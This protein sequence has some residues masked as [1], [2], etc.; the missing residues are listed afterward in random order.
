MDIW[1]AAQNLI[2]SSVRECLEDGFDPNT[3]DERGSTLL[4]KLCRNTHFAHLPEWFEMIKLLLENGANV[5]ITC[6][7]NITPLMYFT[8]IEDVN[9]TDNC[10]NILHLLLKYGANPNLDDDLLNC[11]Y[12]KYSII[13]DTYKNVILINIVLEYV[14]LQ[15][16]KQTVA[17]SK[18]LLDNI[19]SPLKELDYDTLGKLLNFPRKYYPKV[20]R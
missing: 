10:I 18:C 7:Y 16:R 13:D 3:E 6:R 2:V 15:Q 1:L 17:M 9:V 14:E 19:N 20:V 11:A 5:N 4:V 8:E 12:S